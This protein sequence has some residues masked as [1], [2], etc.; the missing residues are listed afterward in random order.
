MGSETNL[1]YKIC[2]IIDANILNLKLYRYIC[3]KYETYG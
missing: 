3:M 2:E 1:F